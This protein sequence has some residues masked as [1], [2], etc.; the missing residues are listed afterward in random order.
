MGM[1]NNGY[2]GRRYVPGT[3][4]EQT[5]AR[6]TCPICSGTGR[7]G[8]GCDTGR[9]DVRLG[10]ACGESDM[11]ARREHCREC[12]ELMRKLQKLDFSIQETVLYLDAYPDCCEAKTYYHH[13]LRER[14]EVAQAYEETCGPLTAWGNQSTTSWDWCKSPWPWQLGFAGNDDK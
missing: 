2:Y 7:K 4:R 14:Q 9:G 5:Y 1:R 11:P 8:C 12:H 10:C 3:A 13:L 6:N